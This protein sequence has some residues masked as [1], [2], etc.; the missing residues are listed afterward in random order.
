MTNKKKRL[1]RDLSKK[2]GISYQAAVNVLNALTGRA[3]FPASLSRATV[4]AAMSLSAALTVACGDDEGASG[5][6]GSGGAGGLPTSSE[7][8]IVTT[9]LRSPESDFAY[10][11][12]LE[13]FPANRQLDY[14]RAL[15]RE[16]GYTSV[17]GEFVYFVD[18][19]DVSITKYEV[20]E[21]LQLREVGRMSLQG[22]GFQGAWEIQWHAGTPYVLDPFSQDIVRF[23]PDSMTIVDTTAVPPEFLVE[24]D[25]LNA[26]VM[27]YR[28]VVRDGRMWFNWAWVDYVDFRSVSEVT[29]SSFPLDGPPVFAEPISDARCPFNGSF[30]FSDPEDYIYAVGLSLWDPLATPN[31]PSCVLR[32]LPDRPEFDPEYELDLLAATNSVAVGGAWPTDQ[33]R[34]LLVQYLA[35]DGPKPADASEF[36]S[37][38]EYRTALVD[39]ATGDSVDVDVPKATIGNWFPLDLDGETF[40]QVYVEQFDNAE[41]TR[42]RPDGSTEALLEAGSGA[43]FLSVHRVR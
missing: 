30:P 10:L 26:G 41:L 39:L 34:K 1:A 31:S 3:S 33:G 28:G 27:G 19:T 43:D 29:M 5:S 9:R 22:V 4:L 32:V 8:L 14:S 38:P 24:R 40:L 7:A 21:E 37:I 36:Y 16:I 15:E 12:V 11:H 25:G 17:D 6:G 2:T 13:S 35:V 18:R 23:D 20:T 42:V